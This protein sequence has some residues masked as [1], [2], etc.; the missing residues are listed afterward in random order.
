MMILALH[1][2]CLLLLAF[3]IMLFGGRGRRRPVIASLAYAL[4]V[5]AFAEAIQAGFGMTQPPGWTGLLL[6][7]AFTLAVYCHQGNVAEL[8]KPRDRGSRLGRLLCWSPM[9]SYQTSRQPGPIPPPPSPPTPPQPRQHNRR[10][11]D[12]QHNNKV[13]S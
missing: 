4:M 11:S 1:I 8:F 6:E 13:T 5:A 9:S 7:L 2:T 3:R 10:K 12:R